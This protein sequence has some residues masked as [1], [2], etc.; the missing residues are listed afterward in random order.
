MET[1]GLNILAVVLILLPH[2]GHQSGMLTLTQSTD[3]PHV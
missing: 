2:L 1:V 3:Y